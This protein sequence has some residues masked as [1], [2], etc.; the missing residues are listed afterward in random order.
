MVEF[1]SDIA[2]VHFEN[3]CNPRRRHQSGIGATMAE[4]VVS[5]GAWAARSVE[6]LDAMDARDRRDRRERLERQQEAEAR[7]AARARLDALQV[8]RMSCKAC[9]AD[10][11]C[12][13][14]VALYADKFRPFEARDVLLYALEVTTAIRAWLRSA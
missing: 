10:F 8:M 13:L 7:E 14:M 2:G 6:E 9:D 4:S 5:S 3:S 1:R 12:D 11:Q